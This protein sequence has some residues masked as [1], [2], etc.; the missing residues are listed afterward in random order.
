MAYQKI[1]KSLSVE[2]SFL[3]SV[4]DRYKIY[5]KYVLS[6]GFA[7]SVH[8]ILVFCLTSGLQVHYLISTSSA[9]VA[10]YFISFFSHKIWTFRDAGHSRLYWQMPAYFLVGLM[11]LFINGAAMYVLVDHYGLYYLLAQ[12]LA[13]ASVA[14]FSFFAYRYVIFRQIQK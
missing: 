14:I 12:A 9:F 8:F 4:F 5:I 7:T 3:Y 2:F 1:K 13:S 6:G 11:N 10:A